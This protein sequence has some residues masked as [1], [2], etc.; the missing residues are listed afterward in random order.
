MST[1]LSTDCIFAGLDEMNSIP[2]DGTEGRPVAPVFSPDGESLAY[3][4]LLS[5]RLMRIAVSGG[6][7]VPISQVNSGGGLGSTSL[8]WEADNAILFT[9]SGRIMSVSANGGEAEVLV[10]VND[11]PPGRGVAQTPDVLP[12]G[13][14]VLFSR[15][16]PLGDL[17]SGIED[18][19]L[20][21]S[22][23][24][25][26]RRVLID[27][28]SNA[29]YVPTGHILYSLENALLAQRIDLSTLDMVGG[30]VPVVEGVMRSLDGVATQYHYSVQG[31]LV[32]AFGDGSG[33]VRDLALIDR[34]Q[35]VDLLEVPS[36]EYA[37]PRVSPDATRLVVE[38]VDHGQRQLFVYDLSGETQIQQLTQ[39]GNNYLPIWTPDS[40]RVAFT[41]D[42]DGTSSLWWRRTDGSEIAEPL[43][44]AVEGTAHHATSWSPD[45]Q[46]LAFEKE[47]AGDM[48]IWT[49]SLYTKEEEPFDVTQGSSQGSAT[50][51]PNGEWLAYHSGESGLVTEIY[52]QPYPPTGPKYPI[53]QTGELKVEPS[54]SPDGSELFYEFPL[55][56][57]RAVD[58]ATAN[59]VTFG[60]ERA[61]LVDN[62]LNIARKDYDVH[63]DGERFLVV[64][65]ANR[66]ESGDTGRPQINI[67]LNWFQEL[68]ER[69]PVR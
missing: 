56:E 62:F 52:V 8:N 65:P 39:E 27:G 5:G 43:T 36:A 4:E 19:V 18:Q 21:Q 68:L 15:R 1:L 55:S 22:L 69:V 11:G 61:V 41:S 13:E 26:E 47:T 16:S 54:W 3:V 40:R 48:D 42:R 17:S 12:G 66:T 33:Q 25:G 23:E 57:L 6:L 44:T 29:R 31:T 46:I 59:G 49:L 24:S 9:V 51:S 32:Y 35:V 20:V 64:V 63:P 14:W 38:R 10:D 67:V 45:G 7:P 28:G 30:P 34:N 60:P 53:A 58:I 50:F 2:V 37:H